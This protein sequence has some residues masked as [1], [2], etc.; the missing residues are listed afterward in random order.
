MRTLE[1][2]KNYLVENGLTHLVR[3]LVN[4]LELSSESAIE[5]VYDSKTL[6]NK[7]F[8]AKYFG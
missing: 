7:E 2:M 3:E 1:E 5:Y 6:S 8:A 4:G